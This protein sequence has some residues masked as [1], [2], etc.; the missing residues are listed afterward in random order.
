MS[1]TEK[2]TT[3]DRGEGLVVDLLVSS[4]MVIIERNH[5]RRWGEIDVIS[6][7]IKDNV[8]HFVEVKSVVRDFNKTGDFSNEE[9]SPVDNMTHGKKKRLSRVI[10]TYV[11]E[12]KL[13]NSDW[14]IDVALVYLD[15]RSDSSKIEM[16]EDVDLS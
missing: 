14:Q 3:G 10:E 5:L 1:K 15:S 9:Y 6:K 12:N 7:N 13:E 4:G 16:I 2:R 8:T 11:M